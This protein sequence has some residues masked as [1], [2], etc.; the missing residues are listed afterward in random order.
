VIAVGAVFF[1]G[2]TGGTFFEDPR[3]IALV[4]FGFF[5]FGLL[6]IKRH[7]LTFHQAIACVT[8]L[9]DGGIEVYRI[10]AVLLPK[11]EY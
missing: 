5:A 3:V 2:I 6:Q 7:V 9:A 11:L 8:G 10:H 1:T 4:D